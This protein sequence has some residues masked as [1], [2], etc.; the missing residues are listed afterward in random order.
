MRNRD[1]CV[2]NL[3]FEYHPSRPEV[4]MAAQK[5]CID[6]VQAKFNVKIKR[7]LIKSDNCSEQYKSGLTLSMQLSFAY[8]YGVKLLLVYGTPMHAHRCQS[9]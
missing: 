2:R 1:N 8:E 9:S 6:L 7:I 5:H 3:A 4:V